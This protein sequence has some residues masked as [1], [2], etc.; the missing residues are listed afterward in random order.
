ML[1]SNRLPS[2][3]EKSVKMNPSDKNN[4]KTYQSNPYNNKNQSV[5]FKDR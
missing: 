5:D 4:F 1:D 2:V 3:M